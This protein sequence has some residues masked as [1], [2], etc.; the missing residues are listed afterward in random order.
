LYIAGIAGHRVLARWNMVILFAFQ[1]S[2]TC[3]LCP[4]IFSLGF[5]AWTVPENF[6]SHPGTEAIAKCLPKIALARGSVHW[7]RRAMQK[8]NPHRI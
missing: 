5:R 7:L 8:I 6:L 3:L 4:P 1:P 2:K